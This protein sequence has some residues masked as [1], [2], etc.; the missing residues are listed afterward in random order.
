MMLKASNMKGIKEMEI[1]VVGD[2]GLIESITKKLHFA[3]MSE[4]AI[5]VLDEGAY[6]GKAHIYVDMITFETLGFFSKKVVKYEYKFYQFER[7]EVTSDILQRI[8]EPLDKHRSVLYK[9]QQK[10]EQKLE[11][12]LDKPEPDRLNI[13]M[14]KQSIGYLKNINVIPKSMLIITGLTGKSYLVPLDTTERFIEKVLETK[15]V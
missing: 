8:K 10:Y 11:K 13:E 5:L 4:D 12:E 9:E 14:Y 15:N 3:E 6:L 1:M 2:M 7:G